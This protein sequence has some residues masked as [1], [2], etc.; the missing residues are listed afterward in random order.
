MKWTFS[1]GLSKMQISH[2]VAQ[3]FAA[4]FSNSHTEIKKFGSP[5]FQKNNL[6]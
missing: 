4:I 5:F 6:S 2:L 1:K 3:P